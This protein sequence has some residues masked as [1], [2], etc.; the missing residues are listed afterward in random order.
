MSAKLRA[1]LPIRLD[2]HHLPILH[3]DFL[4]GFVQHVRPTVDGTQPGIRH[5]TQARR[6][7]TLLTILFRLF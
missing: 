5:N 3:D 7:F 1:H 6:Y 4:D 2:S